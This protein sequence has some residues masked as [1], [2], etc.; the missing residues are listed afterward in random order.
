MFSRFKWSA[1]ARRAPVITRAGFTLVEL[2]VVIAIIGVL[3]AL[4]LPAIQA[5]REAARRSSCSNN[6]KQ[7]GLGLQNYHDARKTFPY[8]CVIPATTQQGFFGASNIGP[9]WVVAVLP[10]IEGG[11]VLSLFNKTA[12]IDSPMNSSF[13]AANLPFMLC[14]SDPFRSIKFNDNGMNNPMI[15]SRGCYAA[16][17]SIQYDPWEAVQSWFYGGLPLGTTNQ[18]WTSL[19]SRGVMQ[20]NASASMSQIIDGTSKTIIV[21]EVRA[22]SNP[23]FTRGVWAL[24][25]SPT[26]LFAHGA[27]S[28]RVGW[29]NADIGPNYA[30]DNS[31]ATGDGVN[32][33]WL[34]TQQYQTMLNLGMSCR[35][36]TWS[37]QQGPKSNHA[38]GLQT[39]FCD[40]SVHWMDDT[41]QTGVG[42][43]NSIG[44]Y[45]MLF[46][47]ADGNSIPQEVFNTN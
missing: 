25:F 21:A 35:G 7:I 29:G 10:F 47:S 39:V 4:L 24:P 37:V 22:D 42:V 2:L 12:F 3:V 28:D 16:N 36:D 30:G 11:N 45:E 34:S 15:C 19:T 46:L 6:L 41:I 38:G 9:N 44:Y 32:G 33:C 40:G 13:A 20:P 14:P 26:S 5:A 23:G 31:G 27:N 1:P 17:A 8:S 43:P 18:M